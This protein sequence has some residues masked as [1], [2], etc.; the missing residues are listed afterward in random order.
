[1]SFGL[2]VKSGFAKI[3]S[4]F[5]REIKL[6]KSKPTFYIAVM[7][8]LSGL[9]Y[10]MMFT[11]HIPIFPPPFSFLKLDFAD[12]GVALAAVMFGSISALTV[13]FVKCALY[14]PF[15][16]ENVGIGVL[17]NFI[18]CAAF[19][20]ALAIIC[21]I[22][23]N[24][25]FLIVGF[26]SAILIEAAVSLFS[27][28]FITSRLF[29]LAKG[30]GYKILLT[31]YYIFGFLLPFNLLKFGITAAL[32]YGIFKALQQSLPP[33][34]G[35]RFPP[36]NIPVSVEESGTETTADSTETVTEKGQE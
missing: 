5:T 16:M 31:P 24:D 8:V 7:A 2:R 35:L 27:N 23:R 13:A 36:K 6:M 9:S 28:Y 11:L 1:M 10:G 22:K 33:K 4:V 29:I 3:F 26:V 25:L 15:D 32:S 12:L 21:R 19:G 34:F 18:C 14:L 30:A 20:L 17:S